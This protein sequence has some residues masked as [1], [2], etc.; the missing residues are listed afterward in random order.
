M[1]FGDR[2]KLARLA[3]GL[4]QGELARI[5]LTHTQNVSKWEQ[6]V[7]EPGLEAKALLSNQLSLSIDWLISGV[8][9]PFH[10]EAVAVMRP[11]P[12]NFLH[13][14]ELIAAA[15]AESSQPEV[16][17]S[18]T[19]QDGIE[20]ALKFSQGTDTHY[21]VVLHPPIGFERSFQKYLMGTTSIQY[22]AV[23]ACDKKLSDLN[24]Q[25]LALIFARFRAPA[26][27]LKPDYFF[28]QLYNAHTKQELIDFIYSRSV[29]IADKVN[30]ILLKAAPEWMNAYRHHHK[31]FRDIVRS[32]LENKPFADKQWTILENFVS[33][34]AIASI[35]PQHKTDY[36]ERLLVRVMQD[37]KLEPFTIAYAELLGCI[38]KEAKGD[39]APRPTLDRKKDLLYWAAE[40][41]TPAHS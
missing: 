41:E 38:L 7:F 36:F 3:F 22:G 35:L 19:L 9:I 10:E 27:E 31:E 23:A 40:Q 21:F 12:K 28:I 26:N 16:V 4:T 24:P 2:I 14:I 33:K 1:S 13:A 11:Q 39:K 17:F 5:G 34:E 20:Y 32:W 30:A 6:K 15:A 37:N 25:E 29:P 18:K 8:G